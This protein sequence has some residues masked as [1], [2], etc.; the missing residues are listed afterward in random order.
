MLPPIPMNGDR[1]KLPPQATLPAAVFKPLQDA[2]QKSYLDL[3]QEAPTLEFSQDQIDKMREYLKA[4]EDFC[5][6]QFKNRGKEYERQLQQVQSELKQKSARLDEDQRHHLHC[7]IQNLRALQSQTE[8]LANHGIPIAYDNKQAKLELI[9]KW[10]EQFRQIKQE[11]AS[12]SYPNRRW[13]DVK[14]IGFR[15]IAAG[16]EKDIKTGQEAVRQMKLSGLLPHEVEN[17]VIVEYVNTV[18]QRVAT[19][20]DLHVPLKVRVLDS[21]EINAFALPGGF[22]FVERGLLEAADDE[23]ELAGV[24]GHEM[25]H[26]VARH[27]HKLMTKATIA[28]IFYQAA[29]IA[30]MVLTGGAM[31]IGTYYALQYGFYGL[32]LVL[33]LKLLGVSREFELEAD[34]LGIQYTWNSDYD[35]SGFIR[36]F[37]K[38]ATK[39]GYVNGLGWFYDHPPFYQRMVDAEREIMLLP[40]KNNLVRQTTE[41]GQMKK[42]LTT[43]TAAAKEEEKNR[44]SLVAP[45]RGCAAPEKIEYKPGQPIETLCSSPAPQNT[46]GK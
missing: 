25:G 43:V 13:G 30:A 1:K 7:Q 23:S 4:A 28:Q 21:K 39:E 18:A 14:D 10:P 11:I 38:I 45:E 5:K 9:E 31:G 20:S 44:P 17:K 12:G 26:V 22:L 15:E 37:D 19:R 35:P 24:L 16:Q 46:S 27:G 33:D 3:F 8:V 42:E 6:G 41:F 36:F 2:L 40:K 34:Q 29:E 32:S